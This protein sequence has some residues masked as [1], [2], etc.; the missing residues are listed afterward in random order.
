MS[1][2]SKQLVAFA[3]LDPSVF[4]SGK[5]KVSNN[6]ISKRGSA[7]LRKVL[8]QA[9]IVGITTPS[10]KPVNPVL[11]AF[12]TKKIPEGKS[13]KV[14]MIACCNKLLRIIYGV[15]RSGTPFVNVQ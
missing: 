8:Y 11:H 9:V 4:E 6:K 2:T 10:E 3:G 5:F 14:A 1:P 7:Y 15:W 13:G 12:Y